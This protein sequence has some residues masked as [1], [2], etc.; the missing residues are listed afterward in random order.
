VKKYTLHSIALLIAI[1]LLAPFAL[2]ANQQDFS[3]FQ[4]A[5]LSGKLLQAGNYEVSWTGSAPNVELKVS[6][7]GKV[8]TTSP[9]QLVPVD[10]PY[11]R[12]SVLLVRNPDGS[13]AVSEFRFGGK[14]YRIVVN[15]PG[16]TRR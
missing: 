6:S 13:M 2:A 8:L 10:R 1:V 4:P 12:G 16:P 9:A 7:D 11:P 14:K 3:L 15:L 5:T